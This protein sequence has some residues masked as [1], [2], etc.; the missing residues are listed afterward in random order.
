VQHFDAQPEARQR[1]ISVSRE[2]DYLHLQHDPQTLGAECQVLAQL[3]IY[4][5][6]IDLAQGH[7]VAQMLESFNSDCVRP[8]TIL[9]A[10]GPRQ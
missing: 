3:V 1:Y 4:R 5:S 6:Q 7:A 10:Q 2:G 9:A 8:G